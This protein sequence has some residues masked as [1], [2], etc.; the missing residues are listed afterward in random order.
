MSEAPAQITKKLPVEKKKVGNVTT[1]NNPSKDNNAAIW[2]A[3][4][5]IKSQVKRLSKEKTSATKYKNISFK[6]PRFG[7]VKKPYKSFE[8]AAGSVKRTTKISKSAGSQRQQPKDKNEIGSKKEASTQAQAPSKNPKPTI[9]DKGKKKLDEPP[10]K[11]KQPWLPS[12][13]SGIRF[14]KT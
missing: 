7:N 4:L 11:K 6:A 12:Y 5:P 3:D 8:A 13:N 1:E 2:D 9:A 10:I 14:K